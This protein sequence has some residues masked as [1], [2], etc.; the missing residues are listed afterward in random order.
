MRGR[1]SFGRGKRGHT[2]TNMSARV[3]SANKKPGQN[4]NV[5]VRGR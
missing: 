4:I 5:R 3:V 1:L 2:T